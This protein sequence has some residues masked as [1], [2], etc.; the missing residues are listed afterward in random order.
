MPKV[1]VRHAG[2]LCALVFVAVC[3]IAYAHLWQWLYSQILCLILWC[4]LNVIRQR[5]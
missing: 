4:I 3:L 5:H 2:R 1:W